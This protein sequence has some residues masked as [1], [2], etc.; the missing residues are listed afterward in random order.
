[1]VLDERAN[2]VRNAA[3]RRFAGHDFSPLAV[4]R[5]LSGV[6]EVWGVGVDTTRHN[7]LLLASELA[8]NAVEHTYAGFAVSIRTVGAGARVEVH[9]TEAELPTLRQ[10]TTGADRGWGLMLVDR[11]ASAW[12]AEPATGGK[13]VWFELPLGPDEP[14]ARP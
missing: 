9:D 13:V 4:R 11:L 1:M 2:Y 14:V 5:F 6:L 8:N 12:G 3:R 10:P 7:L